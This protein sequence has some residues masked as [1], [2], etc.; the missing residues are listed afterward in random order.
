MSST[1][2]VTR[3]ATSPALLRPYDCPLNPLGRTTLGR[4]G[5]FSQLVIRM[6]RTTAL[7][8]RA[9]TNGRHAAER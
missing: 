6:R 4:S 2:L 3:T 1:E 7:R 9:R 8:V 5:R